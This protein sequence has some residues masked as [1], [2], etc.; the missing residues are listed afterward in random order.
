[1]IKSI[2]LVRKNGH[3]DII[4]DIKETTIIITENDSKES[5]SFDNDLWDNISNIV[6]SLKT[7]K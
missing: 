6:N 1:M 4:R 3:V 5:Y 2:R 7:L